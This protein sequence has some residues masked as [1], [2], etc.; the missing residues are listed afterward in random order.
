MSR[1]ATGL[2]SVGETLH[3]VLAQPLPRGV[4]AGDSGTRH[5]AEVLLRRLRR[6]VLRMIADGGPTAAAEA[7]GVG[8]ATLARWRAV[9]G[10]LA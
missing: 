7:L 9:G 6:D 4:S 5:A 3:R 8:R 2:G 10:W 1:P